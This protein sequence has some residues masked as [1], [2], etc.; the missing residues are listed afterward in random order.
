MG[1]KKLTIKGE[2]VDFAIKSGLNKIGLTQERAIITIEK[3]EFFGFFGT[4]DAR[5][6]I[7]YDE[8]ESKKSLD[9]KLQK[10]FEAGFNIQWE[11]GKVLLRLPQDFLTSPKLDSVEKRKEFLHSF[12]KK[13]GVESP[14][15]KNIENLASESQATQNY[16][17]VAEYPTEPLGSR[18]ASILLRIAP[19]KMKCEAIV[20]QGDKATED[21][22]FVVLKKHHCIKGILRKSIQDSLKGNVTGFFEVAKGQPVQNDASGVLEKFFQEDA[23]REFSKM[24]SDL[25]ID[26]R[27][28]KEIAIA[29]RN[30]LLIRMGDVIRGH[31]GWTI[32]GDIIPR[33]VLTQKEGIQL[34]QNVYLSD[35]GKEVYA[36]QPGHVLWRPQDPYIDIDRVYIVKGNVDFSEGNVNFVGKVIV[37][38]DVKAKFSVHAEGDIVVHGSVEDAVI[39]SSKGSIFIAGTVVHHN[40]GYVQ[41]KETVHVTIASN[42]KLRGK[43]IIIEKEAMNSELKADEEILITGSP[44]VFVGGEARAKKLVRINVIGSPSW[45]ATKIHVGNITPLSNELQGHSSNILTCQNQI[46]AAK[47]ISTILKQRKVAE[48]LTEAQ[49]EQL[50]SSEELL[51]SLADQ[52]QT[53]QSEIDRIKAEI[54]TCEGGKLEVLKTLYP[55]V[56]VYIYNAYLL[57]TSK[58]SFTGFIC[59]NDMIIRYPL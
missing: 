25:N 41:A 45:V 23:R 46:K 6:S 59:K 48:P 31:D 10:Q 17:L 36:K 57:P 20:F 2:T 33:E 43:K 15:N 35:S 1:K 24:M 22:F 53:R 34:G 51:T 19:D 30:Q 32:T 49:A 58:E 52:L 12:L 54:A 40:E 3:R 18:G 44:G 21:D 42:A 39:E 4:Q 5:V 28:V 13:K 16:A 7:V 8:E 11:Y 56:D 27:S 9:E 14:L 50:K 29:D 47:Q 26:T 38:G 37:M 55:Q